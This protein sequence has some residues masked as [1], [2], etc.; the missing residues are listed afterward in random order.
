MYEDPVAGKYAYEDEVDDDV[1][2]HLGSGAYVNDP[3]PPGVPHDVRRSRRNRR[4]LAVATVALL[5]IVAATIIASENSPSP[6]A[7]KTKSQPMTTTSAPR[8][9]P[10]ARP[11]P[12]VLANW[13]GFADWGLWTDSLDCS[14]APAYFYPNQVRSLLLTR[15]DSAEYPL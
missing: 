2:L 12:G 9:R 10:G 11:G 13:T 3:A 4:M 5:L 6:I 8:P 1:L 14:G 7:R 15:D